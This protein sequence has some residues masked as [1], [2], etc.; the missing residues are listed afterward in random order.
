M[1]IA[2]APV[3][4]EWQ[5]SFGGSQQEWGVDFIILPDGN[6]LVLGNSQS[7]DGDV[8]GNHGPATTWDIYLA[9]ID[10]AGN[11]IWKKSYGGSYNEQASAIKQTTDGGFIIVGSSA[12]NDGDVSGHHGFVSLNDVWVVKLDG[13]GNI[14]WQKSYGGSFTDIGADILETP[15]GFMICGSTNSTDGDVSGKHGSDDLWI[16]HIDKTGNI[17]WQRCYG[18]SKVED[19]GSIKATTDGA[20]IVASGTSSLDGDVSIPPAGFNDAW[21][22]KISASGNIIWEKCIGGNRSDAITHIIVNNDGTYFLAAYT[23]STNIP[24][25]MQNELTWQ[26]DG[27]TLLLDK[28][29]NIVWQKAFGGTRNDAV[30]DAL[31]TADG[32]YLLIG[33]T[34]SDNGIVCQ[35]HPEE[36][37]WILKMDHAGN[38][39]WSRTFGGSGIETSSKCALDAAGR[40]VVLGQS[41]SA[42]GDLTTNYGIT[43]FWISRYTFTGI[44]TA[45]SVSIKANVDSI[46]CA[47]SFIQFTATPVS[48][49]PNPAYQWFV[50]GVNTGLTGN[51]VWFNTVYDKDVITCE[52]TSD[53][54]CLDIHTATS[55]RETI[56]VKTQPI[57]GFLGKDT[58]ICAYQ[59]M[60]LGANSTRF[61][62]YK[63][64]DGSTNV[65]FNIKGPGTY[66]LQVTDIFNC[67]S[68][69]SIIIKPK[70]CIEGV[71]V[72]NTFT[73]NGDGKNDAFMPVMNADVTA[74]RFVIYDRWGHLVFQTSTINKGWDGKINGLPYDTGVFAWQ[75]SY[76]LFGEPPAV[77]RGTV[78]LLR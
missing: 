74:Y 30:L 26:G 69:D 13:Y 68:R 42:D 48:G 51:P 31:K 63:W 29:G 50:N 46:R 19:P 2:Q 11:I 70:N 41:F 78:L 22:L 34:G 5:K 49:G 33:E 1:L 28:N 58:A 4:L 36:D 62:S 39:A 52:L 59:R 65:Y 8:P 73:P 54:R 60:V 23:G 55:N 47:G 38:I 67:I 15:A 57:T 37:V 17:L 71:F 76:Q 25:A 40:L 7:S 45:P 64:N 56:K 18:G 12:S 32:G 35:R 72:P 53:D 44:L 10:P 27:W 61:T 9:K 20:F 77:K 6:Y 24:G 21:V 43:D 66:W 75:C 3:V 14:S 16:L